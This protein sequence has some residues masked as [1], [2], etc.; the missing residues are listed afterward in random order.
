M[1]PITEY[2]LHLLGLEKTA[3]RVYALSG[4]LLSLLFF[5]FRLLLQ[6]LR[7]CW[8][9]YITCRRLRCFPQP[10]RRNWLLGHLG[11]VCVCVCVAGEV[12]RAGQGRAGQITGVQ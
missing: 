7:F 2:I 10:P 6:F 11:M 4:L 12:G 5:L 1:L 9:F 8:C 3:F